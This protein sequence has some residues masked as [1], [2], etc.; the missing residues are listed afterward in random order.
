MSLRLSGAL[1]MFWRN[2]SFT[3][4]GDGWYQRVPELA[5]ERGEPEL[6]YLKTVNLFH[7]LFF[8]AI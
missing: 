6:C 8:F 7:R 3:Q 4:E 2:Y 5:G 1:G